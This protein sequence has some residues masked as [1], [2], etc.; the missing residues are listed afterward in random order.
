M[1]GERFSRMILINESGILEE[2]GRLTFGG[3]DYV[4]LATANRVF[5]EDPDERGGTIKLDEYDVATGAKVRTLATGIPREGH[6]VASVISNGI[7]VFCMIGANRGNP[8]N[9][10]QSFLI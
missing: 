4:T 5:V 6:M 7:E 2:R 10:V 3:R 8:R 1:F 9:V